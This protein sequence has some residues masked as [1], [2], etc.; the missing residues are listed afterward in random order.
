MRLGSWTKFINWISVLR[1]SLFA[2][3]YSLSR[4]K[5]YGPPKTRCKRGEPS[6]A[7]DSSRARKNP[8]VWGGEQ[9]EPRNMMTV[10]PVYDSQSHELHIQSFEA[11]GA[12]VQVGHDFQNHVTVNGNLVIDPAK[13]LNNAPDTNLLAGDVQKLVVVT[14]YNNSIDL[15][16]VDAA[17][18]SL[19]EY[20][21]TEYVSVTPPSRERFVSGGQSS[22]DYSFSATLQEYDYV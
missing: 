18:A 11:A 10:S 6:R 15:A 9:L 19:N 22:C 17:F 14:Q 8:R 4:R 12:A 1:E 3:F 20:D 5:T 21:T 16:M 13:M 7:A 2:K